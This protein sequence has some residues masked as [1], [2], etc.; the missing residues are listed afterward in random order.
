MC[1][2]VMPFGVSRAVH[3]KFVRNEMIFVSYF[4]CLRIPTRALSESVDRQERPGMLPGSVILKLKARLVFG[5]KFLRY[6]R[7]Q[8]H[9]GT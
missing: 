2:D 3:D 4:C 5:L 9:S 7:T 8:Q 6:R 1:C